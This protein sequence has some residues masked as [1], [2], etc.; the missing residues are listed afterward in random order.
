MRPKMNWFVLR[1]ASQREMEIEKQIKAMAFEAMAPYRELWHR[2]RNGRPRK[3][4]YP[5]FPGYV[6][7]CLPSP[8]IDLQTIQGTL[9]KDRPVTRGLLPSSDCPVVLRPDDVAYLAS[10]AD[11]K[12]RQPDEVQPLRVGDRVLIPAGPLQGF[13]GTILK[14]RRGKSA[15]VSVKRIKSI[16]SVEIS[17]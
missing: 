14:I 11:G 7:V 1:V 3:R 10:I 4:R 9:N 5:L 17:L 2:V 16:K 15:T 6:F 12:Y 8:S 13:A